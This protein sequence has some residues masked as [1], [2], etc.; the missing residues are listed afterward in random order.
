MPAALPAEVSTSPSSTNSTPGSRRT[1]GNRRRKASTCIQCVVAGRPSSSPAAAS[2]K[3]P[4]QMDTSRAC[5]AAARS[6]PA[7][8]SGSVPS[9]MAGPP[10]TPGTTTVP[11][12]SSSEASCSGVTE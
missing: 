1:A 8:S 5:P 12:L 9:V 4:V 2:T 3:A 7:S 10:Y 11:A 6:A